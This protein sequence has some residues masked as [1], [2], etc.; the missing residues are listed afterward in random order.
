[1]EESKNFT[2]PQ[3][4]ILVVD[5]NEMNRKVAKGL[6]APYQMQIDMAE[7]GKQAVEMVQRKHYDIVFMDHMM[8]VMDGLEATAADNDYHRSE[9]GW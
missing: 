7:D 1:M 4:S 9:H 6:M 3:A 2:A 8:P 5:D